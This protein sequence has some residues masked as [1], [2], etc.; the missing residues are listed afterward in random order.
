MRLFS[1]ITAENEKCRVRVGPLRRAEKFWKSY[2]R[3]EDRLSAEFKE[4]RVK[5]K[6]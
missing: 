2:H 1:N 3:K 6:T 4:C 5:L